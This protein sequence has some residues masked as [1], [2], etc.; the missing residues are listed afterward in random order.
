[1]S[2][3]HF[4]FIDKMSDKIEASLTE[5]LLAYSKLGKM[6]INTPPT[7]SEKWW[8]AFVIGILFF[9]L[10]SSFAYGITNGIIGMTYA[11]SSPTIF[12]LFIHGLIFVIIVR[13]ALL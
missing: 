10:S 1:M 7:S 13:L 8:Y 6:T 4:L 9:L 12:G 5:R 2:R 3:S 11:D